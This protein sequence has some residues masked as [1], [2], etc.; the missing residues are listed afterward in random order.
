MIFLHGNNAFSSQKVLVILGSWEPNQDHFVSKRKRCVR[1][2]D[3]D[4]RRNRSK[5]LE[6]EENP[7]PL[8]DGSSLSN[9]TFQQESSLLNDDANPAHTVDIYI[10]Q[11]VDAV[12]V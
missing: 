4:R 7:S 6:I 10:A 9:S 8:P 1:L 3:E 12:P 5:F 11:Q 2:Y